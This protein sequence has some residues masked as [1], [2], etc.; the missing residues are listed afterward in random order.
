[1]KLKR[2]AI[3][4]VFLLAIL[5][6]CGSGD[7]VKKEG[8]YKNA[9]V[10]DVKNGSRTEVIGKMS[11]SQVPKDDITE[12]ALLDWC[13][14]HIKAND[15]SYSIIRYDGDVDHGVYGTGNQILTNVNIQKEADGTY[16]Y[17]GDT[18][19]TKVYTVKDDN[20]LVEN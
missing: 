18:E 20:T 14:N 2:M 7:S 16:S 10:M 12:E 8:I 11:V 13:V 15:L 9:L 3:L 17:V 5:T 6:A 1:M 4:L 19:D